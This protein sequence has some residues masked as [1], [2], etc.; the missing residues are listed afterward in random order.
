MVTVINLIEPPSQTT[1]CMVF[2][3]RPKA[4]PEACNETY[5]SANRKVLGSKSE[6]NLLQSFAIE[7]SR[8]QVIEFHHLEKRLLN[9][10]RSY[11]NDYN[12]C[13]NGYY[14]PIHSFINSLLQYSH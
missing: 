4:V 12:S 8:T 1:S 13:S 9:F 10:A 5:V 3:L 11:P 14:T 7:H 2:L 6:I